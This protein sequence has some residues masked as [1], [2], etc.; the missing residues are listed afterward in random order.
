MY[1]NLFLTNTL[2]VTRRLVFR[3]KKKNNI[4]TKFVAHLISF[5]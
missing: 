2:I 5:N 1:N 4:Y 3:L